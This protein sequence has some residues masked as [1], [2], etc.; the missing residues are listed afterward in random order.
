[1]LHLDIRSTGGCI[2]MHNQ[3]AKLLMA[4]DNSVNEAVAVDMLEQLGY[5]VDVVVNGV[6]VIKAVEKNNYDLILMDC[7]MPVM[8][9]YAA[10]RLL[11]ERERQLQLAQIPIIA[12]TAHTLNG[13]REKCL[14]SGMSDYL[15]KPIS[16]ADIKSMVAKWSREQPCQASGSSKNHLPQ[17]MFRQE[18]DSAHINGSE[19]MHDNNIRI[20]DA[21]AL[22]SMRART[23]HRNGGLVSRVVNLYLEQTPGLLA[24]MNSSYQRVDFENVQLMAHTLKSSSLTIGAV[25]FAGICQ[26]IE[27]AAKSGPISERMISDVNRLY[28]DVEQALRKVLNN[29]SLS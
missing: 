27:N 7:E 6:E 22:D 3:H 10:T 24:E 23:R 25:Y 17:N 1:M 5:M 19:R 26:E 15:C 13:A 4:E 29:E 12:L 2:D 11:R 28:A 14:A 9:G 21:E 20:L 8:D 18:T 16:L